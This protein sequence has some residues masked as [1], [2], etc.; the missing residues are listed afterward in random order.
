MHDLA[1]KQEWR[2][3]AL[4]ERHGRITPA[5]EKVLKMDESVDQAREKVGELHVL[6]HGLRVTP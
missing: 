4:L 2:R 3:R 1:R 6:G 5:M